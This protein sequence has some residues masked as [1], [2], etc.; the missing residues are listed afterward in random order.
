M[1]DVAIANGAPSDSRVLVK[2]R[3]Q[4]TAKG[5]ALIVWTN[6]LRDAG[7]QT[8]I[9]DFNTLKT[10]WCKTDFLKYNYLG[11]IVLKPHQMEKHLPWK[12]FEQLGSAQFCE[13]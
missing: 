2:T 10:G 13:L 9:F 7:R 12:V 8:F 4:W 6:R 3:A 1:R 5:R 11:R